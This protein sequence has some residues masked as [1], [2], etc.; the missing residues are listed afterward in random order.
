MKATFKT[1]LSVV[2]SYLMVISILPLSVLSTSAADNNLQGEGTQESPYQIYSAED[3]AYAMTTYGDTDDIF[4]SLESDINISNNSVPNVFKGV[5]N[6]N[7]HNINTD[8][9]F[10]IQNN[11]KIYNLYYRYSLPTTEANC[12][13]M[14]NNGE[15][16]GVIVYAEVVSVPNGAIFC[17]TNNGTII[18]CASIGSIAVT[19]DG[20]SISS[21]FVLTNN[22]TGNIS[23]CYTVATVTT[24]GKANSYYYEYNL[25]YGFSQSA[26]IE[27]SYYDSTL[28]GNIGSNGLTT[29]YMNSQEFVDL[30]NTRISSRYMKWAVDTENTNNGYPIPVPAYNARIISSKTNYLIEDPEY[31][32]LSVDDG[33]EIYYT[34]D[35]SD[36]DINSTKY[37]EPIL[38]SDTVLIKAVGYKNGE[39]GTSCRFSYAKF[40]GEGTNES[41]YLIDCEAALR[42]IPEKSR[43]ACY[44]VTN[45]IVCYEPFS[46]LG[47]FYGELDGN[48]HTISNLYNTKPYYN[49]SNYC[50]GLFTANYG[51]IQKLNLSSDKTVN[52]ISTFAYKNYGL[53]SECGFYG[54]MFGQSQVTPDQKFPDIGY[55]TSYNYYSMGGFVGKNYG[56]IVNSVFIGDVLSTY[57]NTVGGFVGGNQGTIQNCLFEGDVRINGTFGFSG[58][59][60]NIAGGFV[61]YNN[62]YGIIK[63][64]TANTKAVTNLCN[65]YAAASAYSFGKYESIDNIINCS[66][67]YEKV[68]WI[69]G[70]IIEW[71]SPVAVKQDL[72]GSGYS[73]SEHSHNYIAETVSPTCTEDGSSTYRCESC[74]NTIENL[75]I[76]A[77]GHDYGEE[78]IVDPTYEAKGFTHKI[79]ARCGYDYKYNYIEAYKIE[80]GSCGTNATYTMDTGKGTLIISGTGAINNYKSEYN[81]IKKVNRTTAPW[82]S[83][84]IKSVVIEDGI[85]SI[86]NYAFCLNEEMVEVSLPSTLQSIGTSALY[87]V[88]LS[89]LVLPQG[90][91][92]ISNSAF[93]GIKNLTVIEIPDS[94]TNIEKTAFTGCANLERVTLPCSAVLAS[95]SDNYNNVFYNCGKLKTLYFTKGTG[96]MPDYET[97]SPFKSISGT[98][99]EVSFAEGVGYIG[100]NT[101]R[102]CSKLETVNMPLT[103]PVIG[104][105][106]FK[107]T[108]YYQSTFDENGLIISGTILCDGMYAKGDIVIPDGITEISDE[109][110]KNNK[111]ITSIIIPESVKTV[112][113]SAFY[114]CTGL[115]SLTV[116]C[117]L[118]LYKD[119]NSFFNVTG[120]TTLK[121][122]KGSGVM[123]SFNNKFQYTPW[124]KSAS[125]FTTLH[126]DEGITN[127]SAYAFKDL[128]LLSGLIIPSTVTKIEMNSFYGDTSLEKV[129]IPDSVESITSSFQGCSGIKE[130]SIPVS[131]TMSSWSA[132]WENCSNL[133]K[134]TFTKG[135]GKAV[136]YVNNYKYVP[137]YLSKANLQEVALESGI[138]SIGNYMFYGSEIT[139]ITLPKTIT[140]IGDYSF[141]QCE[142]LTEI[143]IP[144]SVTVIG[145]NAFESCTSLSSVSLPDNGV[146]IS[147]FAFRYCSA[148]TD[149]EIP[150]SVSNMG[151]GS[152]VGCTSL[153]HLTLPSTVA[154]PSTYVFTNCTNIKSID[155][156]KGNG[157]IQSNSTNY[158]Y[159]PW[160][161]SKDAIEEINIADGMTEIGDY[162]F[163][164]C[165]GLTVIDIPS[166]V[167]RIGSYA[168]YGCI[169]LRSIVLPI[170]VFSVDSYAFRNCNNLEKIYFLND[171]CSIVTTTYTIPAT[172][173]I[174]GYP[175][176]TA[177]DYA[178]QFSR[179]FVE[180]IKLCPD[181]GSPITNSVTVDP[182]CTE[183][184]HTTLT[185]DNCSH[186]ETTDIS[187]K[188]HTL[189][190]DDGKPATCTDT[191]LTVGL[192]CSVCGEVFKA[193]EIIPANGH[194]PVVDAAKAPTCTETGLT[195]G[196]HCS[197]CG[198]VIKTQ[199]VIP[200]NGHTQVI[201][202]AKAPTCTE[203]GL[204][205]G[206]HCSVC[207]TVTKAQ[208]I[209]PA[210]GHTPV[211]DVAKL[212]TC[213]ETGLTEGSH[214]SVCRAIIK[215]QEV[216]PAKGHTV[217]IDDAV[218]ATCTHTGL[219]SGAHCSV[220]GETLVEQQVVSMKDHTVVIDNTKSP[221]CTKTGLTE[222]SHCSV[223]GEIIKAQEIIPANGHT[224]VKD[225]AVP[226]DC[227]HTGLTEGSHC[228]VCG[229]VLQAQEVIPTSGHTALTDKGYPATCTETG[230]TE[231]S[232]C[233]VCHEILKAQEVIPANGHTWNNGVV[234]TPASCHA[235][236]VMTYTCTKCNAT[237][238]EP[239]SCL[240]HVW[241]DGVITK[242]PTYTDTGEVLYTCTLCGD[243]HT[244]TI[245]CKEKKGKLTITDAIVRAGDEVQV[246]LFLDENPGITA[247]SI[248]V[249]FPEYFTLKNVQYTDL[250][251]NQ[252]SNSP[253]TKNP[254]TISWASSSTSDVDGTG[255]FAILTFEVDL[256]T[257]IDDY[258]ITISYNANNIFDSS[259][260]NVPFDIGNGT[261]TV[262]KP[263]PGDV[264]RDGNINM[265]DLVLIQ[266]FINHWDVSIV[267]SA[268]DVNDDGEINMKD[269]VLLQR[270]ING[271]EVVLL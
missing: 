123:L 46:S 219:T 110:F 99:T 92:T 71:G 258:P 47:V 36:P 85:T 1:V 135:N 115:T 218:P 116:P 179:T 48:G 111:N 209:V 11:G 166:S 172:T 268:A 264:N 61:G 104:K 137:W 197:V 217:A 65:N 109:A 167:I 260:I 205:E 271:W 112:G 138:T 223:C 57:A 147:N 212:P 54:N 176:S 247:L 180:I 243:K 64:S 248:D 185:C 195:E 199:E 231:G 56:T 114:G 30:I 50:K 8:S 154:M 214:C 96:S 221:T 52:C 145:A 157:I 263:T 68:D 25:K 153:T 270:Y 238:T 189:V 203:T 43:N 15:I 181:C 183:K 5:F 182:T 118:D 255:L 254:F 187:A 211:I 165:S 159:S 267:E 210:T 213:T 17:A 72:N 230:L 196:S 222:G 60:T 6:G 206:R 261:V 239:I 160:Y 4:F 93:G 39:T 86:G 27:N 136:S 77:L 178:N 74:E 232:H 113:S 124:Y 126:L 83:Y 49:G 66:N 79:C 240:E 207:G 67:T 163:Y 245:P 235:E 192:H 37:T 23:N 24:E 29:E 266:Q 75:T 35:G 237:K 225:N 105:D 80:T 184:G 140:S 19:K 269:L 246:K 20:G 40:K 171:D 88:A 161:I 249:T 45:D 32:S 125:K 144:D 12:F 253:F 151:S 241:N 148:L 117:D 186:T 10:A 215:A 9:K 2:L 191:G 128:T 100:Q 89:S 91:T 53:I 13:C 149:L 262:L 229:E 236:G 177:H 174:I 200:A 121:M 59:E 233:S 58:H 38:V 7:F 98:L 33:G 81:Y 129:T 259:L 102:D 201:D 95:S 130:L 76:P 202:A 87:G 234:T 190:T 90:L 22:S 122:T 228:S 31:I 164:Y 73:V 188:G 101:F 226:A 21:G 63:D 250:F 120:L 69:Y 216:V 82:G 168:F 142:K 42:A 141:K 106:A 70:D 252:P 244:E 204:T 155:I 208:E 175:N 169:G 108:P 257:P 242:E 55:Y 51:L 41:P 103:Q 28:A 158:K 26:G 94:V 251:G 132:S 44:K 133:E 107:G 265:K 16:S 62:E 131:T 134:V 256:S 173:T 18:G 152:F 3:F 146:S 156:T 220:C 170:N 14:T 224:P 143:T 97:V 34:I 162:A 127:I 193:Q 227:T 150:E 78:I 84:D 139:S 194:I 119:D 198:T